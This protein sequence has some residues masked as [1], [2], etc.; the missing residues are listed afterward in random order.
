MIQIRWQLDYK[1]K[2]TSSNDAM[3]NVQKSLAEHARRIWEKATI[4][5]IIDFVIEQN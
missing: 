1:V 3:E 4:G 5:V 2:R